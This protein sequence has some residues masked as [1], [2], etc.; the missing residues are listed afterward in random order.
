LAAVA[1]AF[2][3]PLATHPFTPA[4]DENS[5]NGY[6]DVALHGLL[7]DNATGSCTSAVSWGLSRLGDVHDTGGVAC[8]ACRWTGEQ[9]IL[10]YDWCVASNHN[11]G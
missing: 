5:G 7:T 3:F 2:R 1:A 4:M 6:A 10:I 11:R 8:D 9:L